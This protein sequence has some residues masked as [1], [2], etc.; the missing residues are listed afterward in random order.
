[1]TTYEV[2][3]QKGEEFGE[4]LVDAEYP[5]QAQLKFIEQQQDPE[6]IVL[7]VIRHD[8]E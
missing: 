1:M 2:H 8:I 5:Q 6:M 7:C 4:A 3:Y